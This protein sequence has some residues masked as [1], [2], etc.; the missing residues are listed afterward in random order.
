MTHEENKPLALSNKE[1]NRFSVFSSSRKQPSMNSNRSLRK[2]RYDLNMEW[3]YS[4]LLRITSS[5]QCT[6]KHLPPISY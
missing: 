1:E 2:T 6:M 4:L 5:T 3:P